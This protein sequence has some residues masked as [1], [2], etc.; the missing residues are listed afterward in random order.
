MWIQIRLL[1]QDQSDLGLHCFSLTKMLPKVFQQKTIAV[2]GA[3]RIKIKR[4][5]PTMTQ[6]SHVSQIIDYLVLAIDPQV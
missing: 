3:F 5:A 4:L 6:T 2:I 1:R